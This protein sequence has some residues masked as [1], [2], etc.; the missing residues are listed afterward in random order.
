MATSQLLI[1]RYLARKLRNTEKVKLVT[2][3]Q[4]DLRIAKLKHSFSKTPYKHQKVCFLLGVHQPGFLFLLDMGLG[5]TYISLNVFDYFNNAGLN[6]GKSMLVLVPNSTNVAGW[7]QQCKEHA[8]HLSFGG[9]H[10][11]VP[12]AE[13]QAMA[14][15]PPNILCMTYMGLLALVCDRK[16][17]KGKKGKKDDEKGLEVNPKKLAA[18]ASKFYMVVADE[19]TAIRNHQALTTRVC[20]QLAK[21]IPR[22]YCL[23]GTP[24]GK[25]P[26]ALWSQFYFVDNGDTLGSTLGLFRSVFFTAKKNYWSGYPEYVFNKE[27][28]SQ[29]YRTIQHYSIRYSEAEC[30][31]LPDLVRTTVPVILPPETW[32]YYNDLTDE[33]REAKTKGNFKLVGNV[34]L[35]MRQLSGGFLGY[36]DPMDEK[37]EI[38]FKDNPKL[39]ALVELLHEVPEGRKVVVFNEYIKSG[40]LIC[41]RLAKEKIKHVRMYGETRDKKATLEQFMTD[42]TTKVC[43]INSQSGA[44]GLNLQ[45]ANYVIFYES[46]VDPI[47][48]RQAEKRCH[49]GGQTETVFMWD[50]VVKNTVDEKIVQYVQEGKSLFDAIIEGKETL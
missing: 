12:A 8:P 32:Q 6:E 22:R 11:T 36:K 9:F 43:V 46:P 21:Y 20:F 49:R 42:K 33:L 23:T 13:R 48:R 24:M 31:D 45:V 16:E 41:E 4:L 50:L 18:F 14:A 38:V 25:D 17:K 26:Q 34:F 30:Q 37:K 10:E 15:E 1:D 3:D 27:K 35:R 5:K 19:S 28:E 44:F 40:D 39:E 2:D 7:E 47:I 29:L